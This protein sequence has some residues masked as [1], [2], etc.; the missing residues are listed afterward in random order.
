[1]IHS[2]LTEEYATTPT[3]NP[4][5]P[6]GIV[7]ALSDMWE[8]DVR[9]FARWIAKMVDTADIRKQQSHHDK[10]RKIVTQ[11]ITIVIALDSFRVD[12]AKSRT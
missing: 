9:A 6:T 8:T 4:V 10:M 5:M 11:M 7:T 12:I 2:V 1:M 3:K